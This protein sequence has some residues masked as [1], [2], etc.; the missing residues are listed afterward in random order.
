MIQSLPE[1]QYTLNFAIYSLNFALKRL[2]TSKLLSPKPIL[3]F[4]IFFCWNRWLLYHEA[5]K[6]KIYCHSTMTICMLKLSSVSET[7]V[8]FLWSMNSVCERSD[9]F[10]SSWKPHMELY[11]YKYFIITPADILKLMFPETF[12]RTYHVNLLYYQ[13]YAVY[14]QAGRTSII[15]L[16]I[17]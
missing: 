1:I 5:T 10:K 12:A 3:A 4:I 13:K 17:R 6:K 11:Y 14:R 7:I 15:I 9:T 8:M 2:Q 16:R